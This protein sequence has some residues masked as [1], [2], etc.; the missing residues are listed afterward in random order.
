MWT[1][2]GAINKPLKLILCDT[3]ISILHKKNKELIAVPL[4]NRKQ[5][6]TMAKYPVGKT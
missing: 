2:H 1:H 6:K 5:I 4:L 3:S